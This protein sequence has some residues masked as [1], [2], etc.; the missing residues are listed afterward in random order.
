MKKEKNKIKELIIRKNREN[1]KNF[2]LLV[3][4][5]IKTTKMKKM[6]NLIKKFSKKE[7]KSHT[8]IPLF[9]KEK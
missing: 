9:Y 7:D 4:W 5:T 8:T 6:T 1:R 3:V 2:C